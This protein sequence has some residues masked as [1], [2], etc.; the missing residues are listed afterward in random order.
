MV[1]V[2][3]DILNNLTRRTQARL[4]SRLDDPLCRAAQRVR[5]A[6]Q[7]LYTASHYCGCLSG[8]GR[9]GNEEV[10]SEAVGRG[11]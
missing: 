4:V 11:E 9:A 3:C 7:D 10:G 2:N 5:D 8:V 1:G 6:M